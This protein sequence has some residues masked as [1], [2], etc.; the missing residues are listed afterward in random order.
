MDLASTVLGWLT[1]RYANRLLDRVTRAVL[2]TD[3]ER[4]LRRVVDAAIGEVVVGAGLGEEDSKHLGAV[5]REGRDVLSTV[6]EMS[7][8]GQAIIDW[9]TP[10][11][12]TYGSDTAGYLQGLGLTVPGLADALRTAVAHGMAADALRGGPLAPVVSAHQYKIL[13][14]LLEEIKDT[15]YDDH[16]PEDFAVLMT[17]MVYLLEQMLGALREQRQDAAGAA[18]VSTETFAALIQ[19]RNRSFVG[20]QYL[21]EEL[22]RL[23]ASSAFTSGYVFITGEPG[24]GKTSYAAH[25]VARPGWIYHFNS[26][27]EGIVSTGAFLGNVSG[28][29][30]SRHPGAPAPPD[31]AGLSALLDRAAAY[32]TAASPLVIV[33]DALDEAEPPPQSGGNRLA[34]PRALPDHTYIVLTSRPE[35]DLQI[36]VDARRDLEFHDDDDRNLADIREYVRGELDAYAEEFRPLLQS[37]RLAGPEVAERLANR[38]EGNFMYVVHVLDDMRRGLLGP[39][40]IHGLDELPVGLRAYYEAHLRILRQRWPARL[41]P[42]FDLGIRC[43]AVMKEPVSAATLAHLTPENI[44]TAFAK[45]VIRQWR[46]FLNTTRVVSGGGRPPELRYFVYHQSFREFLAQDGIGLQDAGRQVYERGT[47]LLHRFL[48]QT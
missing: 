41:V 45:V 46:Q 8:L 47:D 25:L 1:E 44:D 17:D 36:Q 18:P 37:W 15:T 13:R 26:R 31:S 16:R 6:Q 28:Q 22:G 9:L 43:L 12:A 20:R 38:S 48:D 40:V 11:D 32:A 39:G 14:D 35:V 5:L 7:S 21:D 27:G 19:A 33:V 3:Q 34:L 10:L 30:R 42:R 24:I 23:L 29:L 2:G 4:A